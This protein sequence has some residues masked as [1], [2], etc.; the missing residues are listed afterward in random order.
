MTEY[1]TVAATFT[2]SFFSTEVKGKQEVEGLTCFYGQDSKLNVDGTVSTGISGILEAHKT[3][4]GALNEFKIDL[5]FVDS[6]PGNQGQLVVSVVGSYITRTDEHHFVRGFVLQQTPRRDRD[7]A[8]FII[9]EWIRTTNV[10]PDRSVARKRDEN[11]PSEAPTAAPVV[12]NKVTPVEE[13]VRKERKRATVFIAA[14]PKRSTLGDLKVALEELGRVKD[15]KRVGR[16]D[17]A[18]EFTS[19]R[20]AESLAAAAEFK[21][22][23][24]P[25]GERKMITA[26]EYDMLK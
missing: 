26:E 15:F 24:V 1:S 12:S 3:R 10:V 8:Y 9:S 23:G 14:V 17:A 16:M 13:K 11:K 20:V 2:R 18:V 25:A 4:L 6:I 7:N 22:N 19:L 5:K 21:V